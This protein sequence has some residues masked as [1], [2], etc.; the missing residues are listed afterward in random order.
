MASRRRHLISIALNPMI[1]LNKLN[2]QFDLKSLDIA[3]IINLV[4][5]Y[6]KYIKIAFL[7]G[8]LFI[9][10]KMFSEHHVKEMAIRA[11]ISQEQA[12]IDVIKGRDAAVKN[13]TDFKSSI[14]KELNVF[15]VITSISND[16]RSSGAIISSYVPSQ[17]RD[18][19]LYDVITVHFD[20]ISNTF[21]DMMLFLRKIEKSKFPFRI[22]SWS[23]HEGDN[24][25][26]TF[27]VEISAVL[28]HP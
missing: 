10:W 23:G 18:V 2:S 7:V 20:V 13:L 3:Q 26:I 15:D 9:A 24:G 19:G 22:N 6:Q 4:I 8:S 11:Q 14:P 1:D 17:S 28:I 16:A 12:K 27:T 21:K 25:K 5:T